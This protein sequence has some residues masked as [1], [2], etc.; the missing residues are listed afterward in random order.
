MSD[1]SAPPEGLDTPAAVTAFLESLDAD[2]SDP[3]LNR[4]PE[5]VTQLWRDNLL[6]GHRLDPREALGK[7]LDAEG[8]GV[9]TLTGIPFH[10]MCP[11]HL[12][13]YFG[14]AHVA[15]D[16]RKAIVGIGSLEHMVNA[17]SR[18]MILQETL[19]KMVVDTLMTHL[20]AAGAACAIEATHL[21]M[22]LQGREPRSARVHTRQAAGS[23]QGRHD[24]LPPVTA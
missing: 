5:R 16:P 18:R 10:G 17:C 13:P 11:H 7:P 22:I 14:V 3:E 8:E 1:P 9:I 19:T 20:D 6:S 24:I 2:F 15:Y 23:L 12:L 21:C 4:T